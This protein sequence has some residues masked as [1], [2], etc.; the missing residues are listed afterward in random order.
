MPPQWRMIEINVFNSARTVP[1]PTRIAQTLDLQRL[2]LL[3]PPIMA[4]SAHL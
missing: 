1:S 3:N 2:A 4:W